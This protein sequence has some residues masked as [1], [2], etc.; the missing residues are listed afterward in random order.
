MLILTLSCYLL[1]VQFFLQVTEEQVYTDQ[2]DE[3]GQAE[4][5]KGQKHLAWWE[6][7]NS[8]DL[9]W[10]DWDQVQSKAPW[11]LKVDFVD[12]SKIH[13]QFPKFISMCYVKLKVDLNKWD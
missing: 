6:G 12:F 3:F 9:Q 7:Y 4:T 13:F 10:N 8:K 5:G 1:D 2:S 11:A